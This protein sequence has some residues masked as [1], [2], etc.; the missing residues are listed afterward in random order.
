MQFWVSNQIIADP[1]RGAIANGM[2]AG[3]LISLEA[4][5]DTSYSPDVEYRDG[6]LGRRATRR[7]AG[8]AGRTLRLA[9]SP[10]VIP[11]PAV[12]EE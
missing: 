6:M 8:G 1:S 11:L 4:Y 9:D 10:I 7:F 2:S 3:T 5:L 12:M